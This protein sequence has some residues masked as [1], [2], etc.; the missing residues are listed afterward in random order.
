VAQGRQIDTGVE[1]TMAATRSVTQMNLRTL[2]DIFAVAKLPAD[3]PVPE[4]A[5][6]GPFSSVT[7][8]GGELSIVCPEENV[9]ADLTSE[10]GF[11]CLRV[12]GALDFSTVGIL[13]SLLDPL[14]NAG[15][16][17]FVISTFDTDYFLV[18]A[19]QFELCACALNEAGHRVTFEDEPAYNG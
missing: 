2:R 5:N 4:W 15:V 9:P 13:V 10:R 18:K 14:A 12:A 19:D 8:T 16:A 11:R 1:W 6:T 3:K 17:V 7:R